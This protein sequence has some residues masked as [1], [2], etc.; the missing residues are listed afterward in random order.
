MAEVRAQTFWS[1]LKDLYFA[2]SELSGSQRQRFVDQQCPPGDVLRDELLRLLREGERPSGALDRPVHTVVLPT[3]PVA[4][5]SPGARLDHY[6]IVDLVARGGLGVVYRATDVRLKRSVA[7]KVLRW[8]TI[9][10]GGRERFIREAEI[11]SSLT[12]PNIVAI[13][14]I[15]NAQGVDYIAMEFAAGRTLRE[16]IGAGPIDLVTVLTIARQI[17]DALSALHGVG[18]VHRD[19]K[20]TNVVVTPSGMV[21]VLDFGLAKAILPRP[22]DDSGSGEDAQ[23]L[24]QPGMIVGTFAYMSPEQ[25]EG[26]PVDARSDVFSL[27]AVLYEMLTGRPAFAGGTDVAVLSAVMC[28]D[29][30]P[31]HETAP[32][33]P[34]D[35]ERLVVECLHKDPAERWQ[36]M[37][38]VKLALDLVLGDTP[39][40]ASAVPSASRLRMRPS[41]AVLPFANLSAPEDTEYF[42]DGLTE[43]L[44]N[45]LSQ[46]E[47]LRVVSRTSA[48]EFKG[49][50]MNIR[51]VGAQ[52]GVTTVLEG[53]VRKY[54]NRLRITTQLAKVS[55]GCQLWASRFDREMTDVFDIQD[56][57]AQT[58]ARTLEITLKARDGAP[59]VKRFTRDLEAYHLYLRGRFHWNKRS[60]AGFEKAREYFEAALARDARYAPAYAGL[61]DYHISMASWGLAAPQL[62]WPR[63][64]AAALQAVE[65][66]PSLAEA[67]IALAAYRTYFEWNW[68][69]GEREFRLARQLNPADTNVCTQY[70]TYLIQRGRFDE[71]A[72]EIRR[73]AEIDPLSATVNTCLAGVAY[74]SRD[75]DRSIDICRQAL[76]IAPDDIELA[77]VLGM[78]HAAKGSTAEAV[79]AFRVAC[80]LSHDHPML[81]ALL[82]AASATAG[83][84]AEVERLV[85]RLQAMSSDGYVPPIAWAWIY[86]ALGDFDAAFD[87]LQKAAD[88]HDV[89]L[90]YLMVGPC[91]DPLRSH[92]RFPRLLERIGVRRQEA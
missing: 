48:F 40:R 68:A 3:A 50:A 16:M 9:R 81:L 89:M 60:A 31:I 35:V 67:H 43:E 51:T 28:T 75:Y 1:R 62:A 83:D 6:K 87:W 12:H 78:C 80:S 63:A 85:A 52:L 39:A 37:E 42:A 44:I 20:P 64:E 29:P 24:S 69:E 55:D 91:Y 76:E 10:D 70:G 36:R 47:G 41:I 72:Q 65:I 15:G 61:A 30:R 14:D 46:L 7:I 23:E 19:I 22:V 58:I 57:I 5:L 17:A 38:D 79:H 74:Y 88:A 54:G 11:A 26:K 27:G 13:Y 86:T 84:A 90:A 18:I 82:A 4:P 33:V 2:A 71:A 92:P 59:L 49:K 21:K 77:G 8:E 45:A 56:E 32:H 34:T 53:S 73:A 66:D 25:A